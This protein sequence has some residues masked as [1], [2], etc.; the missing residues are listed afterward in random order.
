M[1]PLALVARTMSWLAVRG[2]DALLRTVPR[3]V[4]TCAIPPAQEAGEAGGAG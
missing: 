1:A 4:A 2:E 3:I